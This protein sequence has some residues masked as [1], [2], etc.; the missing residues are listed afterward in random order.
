M[1]SL[2][3]LLGA[4]LG[5][6][7]STLIVCCS[8]DGTDSVECKQY[9]TALLKNAKCDPAFAPPPV[10]G[11][12]DAYR[13]PTKDDFVSQG[14]AASLADCTSYLEALA[15][16]TGACRVPIETADRLRCKTVLLFAD[17][18][19][20]LSTK[21]VGD[22]CELSN[23]P[24]EDSDL[25]FLEL[26]SKGCKTNSCLLV[27]GASVEDAYCTCRCDADGQ[28]L[29]TCACPEGFACQEGLVERDQA[30]GI[31]GGYCVRE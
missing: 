10:A 19:A 23:A 11:N 31:G 18:S 30:P 26:P 8:H 21:G 2:P 17:D 1:R 20:R 12:Y 29:P 27:A 16:P 9:K 13:C 3:K 4:L 15:G 24:P 5:S 14:N 22:Q 25:D 7:L 28:Q 6:T